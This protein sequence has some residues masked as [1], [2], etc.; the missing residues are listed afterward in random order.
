MLD[1]DVWEWSNDV[2]GEPQA[3]PSIPALGAWLSRGV[4]TVVT[5]ADEAI[6]M[7]TD[8]A[9][10]S[11]TVRDVRALIDQIDECPEL[12]RKLE[13]LDRES[14]RQELW[15]RALPLR[16]ARQATS[17]PLPAHIPARRERLKRVTRACSA[18]LHGAS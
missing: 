6:R 15:V 5:W 12:A 8:G 17:S 4:P 16:E 9:L 10:G 18:A 2:G 1:S 11:L 13:E 7:F 3:C 14:L